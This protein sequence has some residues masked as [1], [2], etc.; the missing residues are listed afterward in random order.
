MGAV[1]QRSV[2][3]I[4]PIPTPPLKGRG[5]AA[6][7][8]NRGTPPGTGRI[9]LPLSGLITAVFVGW[10]AD[11]KLVDAETGLA[12]GPLLPVWRFLV[13]WL[14]PIAVF[15]ILLFGLFPQLIS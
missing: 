4:A 2:R 10:I 3:R 13:A 6:S 11:R 14:C 12:G 1:H 15:L 5:L 9:L 7:P 8:L